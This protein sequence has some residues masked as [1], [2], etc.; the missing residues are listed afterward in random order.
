MERNEVVS[1]QFIARWAKRYLEIRKKHGQDAAMAW[2]D[3]FL[4]P[5]DI[6]R[7]KDAIQEA[8]KK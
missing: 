7:I 8:M 1:D 4:N 3:S 6:P 2:A 5:E